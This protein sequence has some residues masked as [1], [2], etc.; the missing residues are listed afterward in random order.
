MDSVASASSRF[1][2][3]ALDVKVI[4]SLGPEHASATL[5][6]PLAAAEAYRLQQMEHLNTAQQCAEHGICYTPLVFTRQGGCERHAEALLSQLASAVAK[7]ELRQAS[8]VKT[9]LLEHIALC[10]ARS[11]ASAVH[12]RAPSNSVGVHPEVQRMLAE[13]A[14]LEH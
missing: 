14:E 11:S 8:A 6:S 2:R 13:G 9:E 10:I 1:A 7:A 3:T 5:Q 4:N 12:R